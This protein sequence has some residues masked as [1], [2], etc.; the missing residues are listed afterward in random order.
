VR[1]A[2][3]AARALPNTGSIWTLY[4]GVH[5][6]QRRLTD[7]KVNLIVPK[8]GSSQH[9]SPLSLSQARSWSNLGKRVWMQ[10]IRTRESSSCTQCRKI[11]NQQEWFSTDRVSQGH[12]LPKGV[13]YEILL[14]WITTKKLVWC[15]R[16]KEWERLSYLCYIWVGVI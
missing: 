7:M 2:E 10:H 4:Q 14:V 6:W 12:Q 1:E 11:Q 15:Q 3:G 8:E 9:F 16:E 5:C 13:N